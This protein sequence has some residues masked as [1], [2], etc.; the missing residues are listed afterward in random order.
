VDAPGTSRQEMKHPI[1]RWSTRKDDIAMLLEHKHAVI[2]G[3]GGAI[4]GAVARAFAREGAR[5]FLTGRHRAAVDAVADAIAAAGGG[6]EA[7]EVDALDERAVEEHLRA[8][9]A[10]TGRI[11]VS[12]NAIG[13]PQH[14]IQGV[15]LA[16]L[17]P[18]RFTLPVT[19]YARSHF[20]TARA[21]ARRMLEQ[22]S[23]VILTLTAAPARSAAP[24]VGGMAP[25][26]AAVEALTR[27]LAAEL[28]PHGVRVVCLR[29]DGIPE[30]E[31]IGVVYGLHAAA[32]GM[33]REAF[34]ALMEGQTLRKRLPT[35]AEVADVAAFLASDRASAMTGAVANL[36]GGSVVD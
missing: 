34:Q 19:T 27:G 16:E 7:A 4:G 28:G 33:T 32:T 18:E 1:S 14:G 6:A 10:E 9:V 15:P 21:A 24:L 8:V 17:S 36:S 29:P 23:G 20:L 2:Y 25:A 3:A 31:T 12:F 35:L 26:W 11:D 5:V 22:E 13:L 30:T